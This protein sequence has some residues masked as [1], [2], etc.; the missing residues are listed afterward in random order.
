MFHAYYAAGHNPTSHKSHSYPARYGGLFDYLEHVLEKD[1]INGPEVVKGNPA[2]FGKFGHL[3]FLVLVLHL[4]YFGL[5]LCQQIFH[6][7]QK[8]R[9]LCVVCCHVGQQ[10]LNEAQKNTGQ[11]DQVTDSKFSNIDLID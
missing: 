5:V 10:T 9:L 11:I 6:F 2:L 4:G 3:Q 1:T 8:H 7:V